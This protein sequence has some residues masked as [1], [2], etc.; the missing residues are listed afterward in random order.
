MAT[1][2]PTN[3]NVTQYFNHPILTP[4]TSIPNHDTMTVLQTE[5]N[6]N[7]MSVPSDQTPLGHLSLVML[8]TKYDILKPIESITPMNPCT[9]LA[10]AVGASVIA[11]GDARWAHIINKQAYDIY[12]A[13]DKALK[14]QALQEVFYKELNDNSVGYAR[15]TTAEILKHLWENYGQI[16][17]DQLAANV[18]YIATPWSPPTYIDNLFDQLKTCMKFAADGLDPITDT[19]A[20]I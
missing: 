1:S 19:A 10:I 6:A 17:N 7:A 2:S 16:D 14:L 12:M 8:P 15:V 18:T 11:I 3:L 20:I 9:C 13:A 4:I 5:L